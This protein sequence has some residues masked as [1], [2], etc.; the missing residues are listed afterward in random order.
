MTS[1]AVGRGELPG[2]REA[3][4]VHRLLPLGRLMAIEAIDSDG[5]VPAHLV[6]VHDRGRL[7]AMALGALT[8]G[9]HQGRT[10]AADLDPRPPGL[11]NEG[12]H[13]QGR[14]QHDGDEDTPKRHGPLLVNHPEPRAVSAESASNTRKP[15][16]RWLAHL[17]QT[18]GVPSSGR[19]KDFAVWRVGRPVSFGTLRPSRLKCLEKLNVTHQQGRAKSAVQVHQGRCLFGAGLAA[20]WRTLRGAKMAAHAGARKRVALS[21]R[22]SGCPRFGSG[23]WIYRHGQRVST[24]SRRTPPRL[25]VLAF[26]QIPSLQI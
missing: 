2:D 6:L 18:R 5:T 12:R 22:P 21:G 9:H 20:S 3:F 1:Q 17:G 16:R 11:K 13:D 14:A 8:R 15:R 25:P 4:V 10:L 19:G 23:T 24:C 7:V 26:I